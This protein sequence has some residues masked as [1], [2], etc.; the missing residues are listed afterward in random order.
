MGIE[1]SGE[2]KSVGLVDKEASLNAL[3]KGA[4]SSLLAMVILEYVDERNSPP[5]R[6]A[7]RGKGL[8]EKQGNTVPIAS[9][10]RS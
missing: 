4:K 3:N 9:P 5:H 10:G 8:T 2:L 6:I 7:L 1:E